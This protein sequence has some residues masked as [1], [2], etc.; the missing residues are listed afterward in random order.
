MDER[1]RLLESAALA[2]YPNVRAGTNDEEDCVDGIEGILARAGLSALEPGTPLKAIEKALRQLSDLVVDVDDL[3]RQTVRE[4][5]VAAIT[6]LGIKSPAALVDKA[7]KLSERP[8]A[9]GQGTAVE[10]ETYDPWPHEVDGANLLDDLKR[11]VR[12]YV[13]ASAESCVA[14][15]LW[16]VH[17][18]AIALTQVSPILSITSPQKRCGKTTLMSVLRHLV[19]RALPASSIS[20]AAL[21]RAIEAWSPTLL[22]D[23]ADTFINGN[24]ALRGVINAGHTRDTAFVIRTV[25][26][27]HEP[28]Q[29]RVFAARALAAIGSLPDTIADRSISIA[30]ERRTPHDTADKWRSDR[31]DEDIGRLRRQAVR[32]VEDNAVVLGSVDPEV[33]DSLHDR[34][35]DCWRPLLAIAD[36]AGGDWPDCARAAAVALSGGADGDDTIAVTLLGDILH[37]FDVWRADRLASEVMVEAL[38]SLLDRPWPEVNRGRPLTQNRLAKLLKP[39]GISSRQGCPPDNKRGYFR[40]D[41]EEPWERYLPDGGTQSAR[42][43]ESLQDKV[44]VD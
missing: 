31:I 27:D 3:R 38:T 30:L 35:A 44:R 25:G 16:V 21:F 4:A 17:T 42:A 12:R 41:F 11:M 22:V 34:A 20:P 39:F 2:P 43:L 29:F 32:W 37:V 33:P 36:A 1:R 28:R 13:V 5:A 9:T 7:L 10:F 23:E 14:I 8:I 24:D 6:A 40:E 26:D 19:L 15:A 18:Y